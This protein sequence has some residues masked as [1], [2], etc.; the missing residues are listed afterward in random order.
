MKI[1][2]SFLN[3]FA[4]FSLFLLPEYVMAQENSEP[5]EAAVPE[6]EYVRA[7]FENGVVINNQTVET[8]GQKSLDFIIQHRFGR[9]KD[10]KDLF[11]LFAPANIRFGL[12]YGITDR[13]V[14][15]VGV[16]KV[17]MTYDFEAKY[18]LLKQTKGKGMPVS[19]AYFANVSKSSTANDNFLNSDGEYKPAYKYTY[20]HELMLAKKVNSKLSLQLAGTHSHYNIIDSAFQQHDFFGVSFVGRYKFSPQS[21]IVIDADYLLNTPDMDKELKPKPNLS[22]GYE[23]STGSHQFQ[24]FVCTADGILEHDNLVFNRNDFTKREVVIGFNITRVWGFK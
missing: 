22:L 20:F 18:V 23:V 17:R 3:K 14:V 2:S 1:L 15:A 6:K 13:L 4:A 21:S 10:E 9:V 11:G 16:T 24:V 19:L 12:G 7:T 8:P 5:S